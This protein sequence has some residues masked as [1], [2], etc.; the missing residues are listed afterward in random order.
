MHV[1]QTST[2]LDPEATVTSNEGISGCD[3]ISRKAMAEWLARLPGDTAVL[4][5]VHLFYAEPSAYL[6][7]DDA[8]TVHTIHQGE[9]GEEGDPLM[10]L[11]FALG[12]HP[13]LVA[14]QRRCPEHTVMA[15]LD[16]ICLVSKPQGVRVGYSSVEQ[17]FWRHAKIRVHEGQ[18][19]IWNFAGIKP[20]ICEELQRLAEVAKP[21]ARVWR[22][23]ELPTEE[24]GIKV[25]GALVG[26][27][28]FI[29]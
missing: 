10:Q 6:W 29:R 21:G 20:D 17:E 27:R 16:D 1:L 8:G 15:F 13:A 28:D 7:E 12:Q 14:I 23:S 25:L 9:G 11:F 19:H 24:Q 18:A 22:G 3:S 5:F 26:H 2:E 4:P